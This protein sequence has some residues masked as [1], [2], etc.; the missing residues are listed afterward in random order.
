MAELEDFKRR[1]VE[2]SRQVESLTKE[3]TDAKTQ[4]QARKDHPE[5]AKKFAVLYCEVKKWKRW[6]NIQDVAGHRMLNFLEKTH[7]ELMQNRDE[8]PTKS[9]LKG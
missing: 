8:G 6:S 5:V 1:E 3:S 4:L 7:A 2:V 9:I